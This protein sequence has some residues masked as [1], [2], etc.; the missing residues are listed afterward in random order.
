MKHDEYSPAGP[1]A[2][3]DQTIKKVLEAAFKARAA[4]DIYVLVDR[5]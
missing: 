4:A 2:R 1:S 3:R 5:R